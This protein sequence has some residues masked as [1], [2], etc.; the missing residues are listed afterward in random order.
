MESELQLL[1]ALEEARKQLHITQEEV[2]TRMVR[3]R[4]SITRL[5]SSGESNPTLE[6]LTDLLMVLGVTADITLRRSA[7]G[8]APIQVTNAL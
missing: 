5:L 6:T 1:H 8:E 2:A 3:Q 4:A 7:E